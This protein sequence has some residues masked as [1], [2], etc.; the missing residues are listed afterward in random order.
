[1]SQFELVDWRGRPD[2]E[3]GLRVDWGYAE[4]EAEA[5]AQ[6]HPFVARTRE[7]WLDGRDRFDRPGEVF[8]LVFDGE[9]LVGMGGLSID[10]H[11]G[12]GSA[13]RLRHVY[14][15][16]EYRRR[17]L[18]VTIVDRCLA[19]ARAAGSFNR[20]RLRTF[21]PVAAALYEA[22][23]FAP[24]NDPSATHQLLLAENG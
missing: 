5:D 14:V 3:P 20:V 19:H 13:A 10:P 24:I 21:N 17:R 4:M 12:D 18:A 9:R 23:G 22:L 11:L 8:F 7:A 1:M 6:G 15:R 2:L 16:S